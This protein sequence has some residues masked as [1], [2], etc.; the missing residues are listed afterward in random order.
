MSAAYKFLLRLA[1]IWVLILPVWLLVVTP[2]YGKLLTG[3]ANRIVRADVLSRDEVR[4]EYVHPCVKGT[5][6]FDVQDRVA[7]RTGRGSLR[8]TMDGERFQF[9]LT[10][11]AALLLA[12][13]FGGQWGR[14]LAYFA[15]GAVIVFLVQGLDL[16]LQ[17]AEEKL[18]Y[19]DSV[20]FR[21]L[22][23]PPG[24][25]DRFLGFCGRYFLLVGYVAA[26]IALW[27]TFG[28]SYLRQAANLDIA[29]GGRNQRSQAERRQ[30]VA[31]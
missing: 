24:F 8:F 19:M 26:P 15:L 13:P 11:W 10:V 20:E 30:D 4:Y 21:R 27:I 5:I 28:P 16:Y 25:Y 31:Q 7:A 2:H 6:E 17:T 12:T 18:T 23:L 29:A 3:A 22:Y 9:S 14:K 1:G